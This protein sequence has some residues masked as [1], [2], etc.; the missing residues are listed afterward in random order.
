MPTEEKKANQQKEKHIKQQP[1]NTEKQPIHTKQQIPNE[2]NP[3]HSK[4]QR[5]FCCNSGQTREFLQY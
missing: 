3:E 1:E 2:Q 5:E 4:Q